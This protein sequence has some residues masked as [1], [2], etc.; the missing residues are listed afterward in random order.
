MLFITN[1]THTKAVFI[2]SSRTKSLLLGPQDIV[3]S[4]QV[5]SGL[6]FPRRHSPDV[7]DKYGPGPL[8]NTALTLLE[9]RS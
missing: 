1:F 8:P 7:S 3:D 5:F 4:N 2:I 9:K 6:H